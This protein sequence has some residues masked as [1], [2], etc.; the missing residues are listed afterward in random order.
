MDFQQSQTYQNV[1]RAL[2]YELRSLALFQLFAKFAEQEVLIEIE[3]IFQTIAGNNGFIAERLRRIIFGENTPTLVNLQEA[4]RYEEDADRDI[5]RTSARIANQEGY[6]DIA[7]LFNGIGN[8]K[9]NHSSM[10]QVQ[11][12][13]IQDNQQFCKPN[14]ALW[15]CMGCGN[16]LNGECAPDICPIC[17][18]PQGY[19]RLY[20]SQC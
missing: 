20:N 3:N 19:Y 6:H 9:L 4:L 8:I 17:G 16:I 2:D 15:V 7:S 18:Y 12:M 5:Y 14:P 11:M 10:L 13:N 1:Q